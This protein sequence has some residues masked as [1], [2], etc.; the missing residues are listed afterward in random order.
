MI[1]KNFTEYCLLENVSSVEEF[2]KSQF[3]C[4]SNKLKKYFDKSF[5]NKSLGPKAVLSLPLDF[6]NAGEINPE[7]SGP[8]IETIY[9]D[10][11]FFVMNKPHNLFVHP[12][13]YCEKNNCLSF[14]RTTEPHLLNINKSEYDR[15]LLYRLDFETSGVLV[16]VKNE[17]AYRFLREN[18]KKIAKEKMYHCLVDGECNLNGNFTHYFSSGEEKGKRVLVQDSGNAN[19]GSL[20]LR[21]LHYN[22]GT[23]TTLMEVKLGQ[24]LRHQI[25][26]QLSHLGFPIRGDEF[27]GGKAARRLYLNA[28]KY[29]IEFEGK[30]FLF[31]KDASDFQGL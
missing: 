9:E 10:E 19:E 11:T 27:Y 25:R 5:L 29:E 26:A 16:Y 13:S 22:S 6:A 12:L 8:L 14:L 28:S 1:Q 2:L 15:G 17:S 20:T 23:D 31:S 30:S 7:Y 21:S 18:F 24:G 4:S 3:Q